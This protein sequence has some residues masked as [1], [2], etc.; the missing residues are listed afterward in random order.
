MFD[1][2]ARGKI[3]QPGPRIAEGI[4][5]VTGRQGRTCLRRI[6]QRDC[7]AAGVAQRHPGRGG[8]ARSIQN[9]GNTRQAAARFTA[10]DLSGWID[11]KIAALR[12]CTGLADDGD[13]CV[14]GASMSG[15][16]LYFNIAPECS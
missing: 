9:K 10:R 16:D 12:A 14:M 11:R 1:A 15:R 8:W 2:D 7:R 6:Y 5:G 4:I 3:A 13:P